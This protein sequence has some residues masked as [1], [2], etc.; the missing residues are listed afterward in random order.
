[1]FLGEVFFS[2]IKAKNKKLADK[3][4]NEPKEIKPVKESSIKESKKEELS[5]S[6][7]SLKPP[8]NKEMGKSKLVEKDKKKEKE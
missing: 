4:G 2:V 1:M 6:Q 3:I 7:V 5:K 8:Q